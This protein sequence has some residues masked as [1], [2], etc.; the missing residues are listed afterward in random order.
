MK[1]VERCY[2]KM[3]TFL[4]ALLF[5]AVQG[6]AQKGL[7]AFHKSWD[8]NKDGKA[9]L[10]PVY[11]VK[12]P[13]KDGYHM[14]YRSLR[15]AKGVKI[16]YRPTGGHMFLGK[17]DAVR[18]RWPVRW[19]SDTAGVAGSKDRMGSFEGS[20]TLGKGNYLPV[21]STQYLVLT[22][23]NTDTPMMGWIKIKFGGKFTYEI[24]DAFFTKGVCKVGVKH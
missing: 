18:A 11:H 24:E 6:H 12:G 15:P 2:M 9:D 13:D 19:V 17:G 5:F 23:N 16:L 21:G 7:H 4:F 8:V 3:C 1:F 20:R 14:Q 22:L 10:Y